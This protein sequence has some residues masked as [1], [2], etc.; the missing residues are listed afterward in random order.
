MFVENF[1]DCIELFFDFLEYMVNLVGYYEVDF[2]SV[3]LVYN[4]CLEYMVC[5]VF[6]FYGNCE[7]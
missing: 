2:Y 5:E 1:F 6:Y 7:Y 4:W 3:C